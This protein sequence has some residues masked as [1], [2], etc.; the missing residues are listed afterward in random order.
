MNAK[1]TKEYC[2][3][4]ICQLINNVSFCVNRIVTFWGL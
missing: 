1:A 3:K 4:S 2:K